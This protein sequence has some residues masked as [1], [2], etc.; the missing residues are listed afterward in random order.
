MNLTTTQIY[1]LTR[2]AVLADFMEFVAGTG[3]LVLVVGII[4]M[5]FVTTLGDISDEADKAMRR[6]ARKL[7]AIGLVVM[8]AAAPCAFFLPTRNDLLAMYGIPAIKESG[9]LTAD[10]LKVIDMLASGM[11]K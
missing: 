1:W 6:C 3:A 9:I 11:S 4:A 10:Q 2:A 5:L 8:L 7:M